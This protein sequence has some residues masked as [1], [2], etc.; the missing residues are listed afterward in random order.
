[1][2]LHEA[3]WLG[4]VHRPKHYSEA[5]TVVAI[6]ATISSNQANHRAESDSQQKSS[7]GY[8]A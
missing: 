6:A 5:Q 7:S 2:N 1:M 8:Q 4:I 3:D